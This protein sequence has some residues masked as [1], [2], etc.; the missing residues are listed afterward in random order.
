MI[1]Y[2][3]SLRSCYLHVYIIQQ[4]IYFP[5]LINHWTAIQ[6]PNIVYMEL[7]LAEYMERTLKLS[8]LTTANQVCF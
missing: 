3:Q 8:S 1:T 7:P 5:I 2:R 6:A 4:K